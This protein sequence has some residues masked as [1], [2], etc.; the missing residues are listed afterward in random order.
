MTYVSADKSS[1]GVARAS[2]M[3]E[4]TFEEKKISQWTEK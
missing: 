4:E 1:E 3:L 2:E